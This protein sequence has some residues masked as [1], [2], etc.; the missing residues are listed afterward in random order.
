MV[1]YQ[2]ALHPRPGQPSWISQ[3]GVTIPKQAIGRVLIRFESRVDLEA[4]RQL[5][6]LLA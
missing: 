5:A 3:L 4:N 2:S 6:I 1:P